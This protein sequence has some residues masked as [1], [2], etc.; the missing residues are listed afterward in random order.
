M[1][2]PTELIN[3]WPKPMPDSNSRAGPPKGPRSVIMFGIDDGRIP[4][5]NPSAGQVIEARRLFYVGFIRAKSELHLANSAQK[6]SRFIK[7]V[8]RRL[9]EDA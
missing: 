9:D 6:S 3:Q 8:E 1:D 4:F 7:V 2:L 5:S